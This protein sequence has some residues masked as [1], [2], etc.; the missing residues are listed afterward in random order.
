[1]PMMKPTNEY[2]KNGFHPNVTHF[3]CFFVFFPP[4]NIVLILS[5]HEENVFKTTIAT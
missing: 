2:E 4:Q 3:P 5:A 1:M